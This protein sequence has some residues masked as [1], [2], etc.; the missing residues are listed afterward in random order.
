ME[1][2]NQYEICDKILEYILSKPDDWHSPEDI[3]ML[4]MK[5]VP[6]EKVKCLFDYMAINQQ[7]EPATFERD[8]QNNWWKIKKN[9][10]TEEFLKE[11]G[12]TSHYNS[13]KEQFQYEE[14]K[15]ELEKEKLLLETENL[16]YQQTI[17]NQEQRIRDLSEQNSFIQ[18]VKNYWWLL[19]FLISIGIFIGRLF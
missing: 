4:F 9:G 10:Y 5:L 15:N 17:R 19:L 18:L 7:P 1:Q 6:I 13:M 11:G 3:R 14:Q 2:Y 8:L 16:K 12:F